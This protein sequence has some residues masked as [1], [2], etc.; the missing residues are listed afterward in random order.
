MEE[1]KKVTCKGADLLVSNLGRVQ[2]LPHST[3]YTRTRNG[4][5]Q[6]FTS[7]FDGRILAQCVTK[8]GYFEVCLNTKGK[9]LKFSVHRLVG[10]AFC[11]GYKEGLHINHINGVKTD[12]APEN[13][14]WVTNEDNVRH[15]WDTGLVDLRGEKQPGSKLTQKQVMVIRK[16]LRDG[17]SAN[18]LSIVAGVSASLIDLIRDGKRWAHLPEE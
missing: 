10:M 2:S 9:R 18:S 15:A 7:N 12:N 13:L 6:S 16:L 3:T 14:E 8:S 17:V 5:T 1:W 4:K 11:D